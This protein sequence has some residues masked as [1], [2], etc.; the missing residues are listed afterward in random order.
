LR[1][2]AKLEDYF[3]KQAEKHNVL[4]FKFLSGVTGVPD[5]LV[6][7]YGQ[8]IFVEL[9]AKNGILSKRQTFIINSMRNH[10]AKV[11]V[12]FSKE[13]IDTFFEKIKQR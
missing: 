9:K 3:I 13:D 12:P 4:Q 11:F 7:G 6:I 2:E 1:P 10:G 8:T 5:R